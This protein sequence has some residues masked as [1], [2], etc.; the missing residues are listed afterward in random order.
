MNWFEQFCRWLLKKDHT[1]A[2]CKRL[3]GPGTEQE[4]IDLLAFDAAVTGRL[5]YSSARPGR[6]SPRPR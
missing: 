6:N 4:G 1:L 3:G 5:R 2:G